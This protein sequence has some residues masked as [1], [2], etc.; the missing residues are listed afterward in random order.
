TKII[1]KL[2]QRSQNSKGALE[3]AQAGNDLIAYQIDETRKLRKVIMDQ[4]NMMTNYSASLNNE[5]ILGKAKDDAIDN[6]D[7]RNNPYTKSIPEAY[8]I[9]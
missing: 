6:K 9:R 2:K 4:S 1:A 3:V 5:K 8:K 7:N